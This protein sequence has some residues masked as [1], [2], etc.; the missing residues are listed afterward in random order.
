[1]SYAFRKYCFPLLDVSWKVWS[2]NG[3]MFDRDLLILETVQEI[4]RGRLSQ[5][6]IEYICYLVFHDGFLS[7]ELIHNKSIIRWLEYWVT[8]KPNQM[9][10]PFVAVEN[11]T[12]LANLIPYLEKLERDNC[13]VMIKSPKHT[14][15]RY[16]IGNFGILLGI[17]FPRNYC[18][19]DIEKAYI[20]CNV[21]VLRSTFVFTDEYSFIS[22]DEL[23]EQHTFYYLPHFKVIPTS[24]MVFMDINLVIIPKIN[25]SRP[26]YIT[27][28]KVF[29]SHFSGQAAN[30][31][32]K[33]IA[34]EYER[35]NTVHHLVVVDGSIQYVN[36]C[37]DG[38]YARNPFFGRVTF[39]V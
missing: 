3:H 5:E 29:S 24:L 10:N 28:M 2:A 30:N 8:D 19:E 20:Q 18:V 1:M 33:K 13:A 32:N 16:N 4:M 12:V 9:H 36:N 6:L 27:Q 37:V 22:K 35:G 38:V 25:K 39:P 31:M 34:V 7:K 15:G 17:A 11:S 23:G 26:K 14:G 21:L